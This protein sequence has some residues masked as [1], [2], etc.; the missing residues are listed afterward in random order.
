MPFTMWIASNSH[1]STQLPQPKHPSGQVLLPPWRLWLTLQS[2]IPLYLNFSVA[3]SGVPWHITHATCFAEST[4][5]APMNAASLSA[6]SFPPTG[7][8]LQGAP[9]FT[10]ASASPSQPGN[11]QAPQFAPGNISLTLSTLLSTWTSNFLDAKPKSNANKIPSAP[12]IINGVKIVI[13]YLLYQSA[14]SEECHRH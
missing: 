9:L 5:S 14:E 7:Q 4:A 8:E 1:T 11:P 2:I 3:Y 6:V 10:M 12:K 13:Y